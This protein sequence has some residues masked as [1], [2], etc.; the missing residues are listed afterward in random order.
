MEKIGKQ[1]KSRTD[2]MTQLAQTLVCC[3]GPDVYFAQNERLQQVNLPPPEPTD[4]MYIVPE[5]IFTLARVE[6]YS[7]LTHHS[8]S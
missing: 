4:Y 6:N 2:R 8:R 7:V 1:K 3:A 5:Q